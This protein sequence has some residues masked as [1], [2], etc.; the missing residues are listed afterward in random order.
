M[1]RFN[2]EGPV[3]AD[4]HYAVPPLER[5]DLADILSLVRDERY[6]VLHAPRQTGK[7]TT[8]RALRDRLNEGAAGNLCCV[9]ASLESG[10][11]ARENLGEAMEAVV[12]KLAFEAGAIGD[13]FLPTKWRSILADA[14]PHRALE[15]SLARWSRASSKPIVLLL[16]ELDALVDDALLS[17]LRQLRAGYADR[18]EGFPQSVVLC[19]LRDVRVYRMPPEVAARAPA[20]QVPF[21]IV[22]KSFR[23]RDFDEAETRAPCSPNTRRKP[24]RSSNRRPWKRCGSR[25]RDSPGW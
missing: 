15:E 4:R 2:T 3:R 24:G 8:L 21:N 10:Q 20:G 7:T 11:T 14:G 13:E 6:F 19:G 9:Y 17:V 23:L 18:P 25:R 12:G 16:D 22:S 5:V 1:R